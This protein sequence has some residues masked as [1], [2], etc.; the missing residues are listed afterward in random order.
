MRTLPPLWTDGSI[1]RHKL[2][3][4]GLAVSALALVAAAPALSQTEPS[5]PPETLGPVDVPTVT[6]T[7]LEDI[8][9][10]T[11][12][13]YELAVIPEFAPFPDDLGR[14]VVLPELKA[15]YD[16]LTQV[17]N[18]ERFG[19]WPYMAGPARVRQRPQ[20]TRPLP[21]RLPG[22]DP[23]QQL[24]RNAQ[25]GGALS[26]GYGSPWLEG[27]INMTATL[28]PSS[29]NFRSHYTRPLDTRDLIGRDS[30]K[31]GSMLS[32]RQSLDDV[33]DIALNASLRREISDE[34]V[35]QD[36]DRL[37]LYN[38]GSTS[39]AGDV[40]GRAEWRGMQGV[41]VSLEGQASSSE[42]YTRTFIT[43][44]DQ[45]VTPWDPL[46]L[47]DERRSNL[48]LASTLDPMPKVSVIGGVSLI[49]QT[50]SQSVHQA[51]AS[52]ISERD[53]SY[54]KPDV[55]LRWQPVGRLEF[56]LGMKQELSS[57]GYD[58]LMQPDLASQVRIEPAK[59]LYGSARYTYPLV[60]VPRIMTGEFSLSTEGAL[61][62][63]IIDHTP[64]KQGDSFIDVKSNI[65]EGR[66]RDLSARLSL[67]SQETG[68]G[69][70]QFEMTAT[71]RSSRV[72]DPLMLTARPLSN[73]S[74]LSLNLNFRQSLEREGISWGVRADNGWQSTTWRIN[75]VSVSRANASGR[76]VRRISAGGRAET[77]GRIKQHHQAQSKL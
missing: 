60:I 72:T 10:A 35:R 67:N 29:D 61:I 74:P 34:T 53:I 7:P 62:S 40:S 28:E 8:S 76:P 33:L 51:A 36:S 75:E 46:R 39:V 70:S 20:F 38:V 22:P 66:T 77:A 57:I 59:Y 21:V 50:L 11:E 37:W 49:S 56:N 45:T 25:D 47:V 55:R 12:P 2:A 3:L 69:S 13:E 31:L 6:M 26:L 63:G 54:M 23:R 71:W 65:G 9:S 41:R 5:N 52:Q 14:S 43:A 1:R 42:R 15:Y 27:Q 44:D 18:P 32:Y 19:L 24:T 4:T 17:F 73:Q 16:D 30:V 48:T 64:L 68:I 58:D